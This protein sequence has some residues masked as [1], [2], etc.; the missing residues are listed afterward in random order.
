MPFWGILMQKVY[1]SGEL[2]WKYQSG[3]F[4]NGNYRNRLLYPFIFLDYQI[5]QNPKYPVWVRSSYEYG[6]KRSSIVYLSFL[7]VL[8]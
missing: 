5:I 3:E 1:T 8:K 6:G 7:T 2:S 4:F